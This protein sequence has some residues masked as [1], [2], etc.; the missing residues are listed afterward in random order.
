MA[1]TAKRARYALDR[2]STRSPAESR[3]RNRSG[4][5]ARASLGKAEPHPRRPADGETL[6][7]QHCQ[8]A[9]R[10]SNGAPADRKGDQNPGAGA[11]QALGPAAAVM[12]KL[13][14]GVDEISRSVLLDQSSPSRHICRLRRAESP[15]GERNSTVN[16]RSVRAT[17]SCAYGTEQAGQSAPSVRRNIP[18]GTTRGDQRLAGRS[19]PIGTLDIDIRLIAAVSIHLLF[20][21][22]SAG[23][24]SGHIVG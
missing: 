20:A 4:W 3:S 10:Q 6:Q 22:P 2:R 17:R 14:V 8:I 1:H 19:Q 5:R 16:C 9:A 13:H 7:H 21:E 12:A 23:Q 11:Q 15:L 18:S 24:M